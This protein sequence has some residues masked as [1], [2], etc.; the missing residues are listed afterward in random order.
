MSSWWFSESPRARAAVSY[1]GNPAVLGHFDTDTPP[2]QGQIVK[3]GFN[4]PRDD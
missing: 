2:H 3:Q 1:V 4:A